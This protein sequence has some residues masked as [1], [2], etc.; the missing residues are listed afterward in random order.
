MS[1][2]CILTSSARYGCTY[3]FVFHKYLFLYLHTFI[4]VY[5]YIYMYFIHNICSIDILYIYKKCMPFCL[6][7]DD[8][9]SFVGPNLSS[10]SCVYELHPKNLRL[11]S[12]M[13]FSHP[14]FQST[15]LDFKFQLFRFVFI[16]KSG[17][18]CYNH[19]IFQHGWGL[20]PLSQTLNGAGI[21]AYIWA[22]QGV[23]SSLK[24]TV[25]PWK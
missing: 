2:G 3:F 10:K 25:R 8:Q 7:V 12:E 15:L 17:C 21:F 11:E 22:V 18:K 20:T 24:L 4:Y 6:F 5:I 16:K 14:P 9:I 23:I 1:K 19:Y 13:F